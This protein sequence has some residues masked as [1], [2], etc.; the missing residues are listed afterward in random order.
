MRGL[1]VRP[2]D[3]LTRAELREE[4]RVSDVTIWRWQRKGMPFLQWTP[5]LRRYVLADVRNWLD[6]GGANGTS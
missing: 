3:A 4:L 5:G 1:Q 6:R 2:G